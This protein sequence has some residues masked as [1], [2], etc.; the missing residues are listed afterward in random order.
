MS[1]EPAVNDAAV[2]PVRRV[3]AFERRLEDERLHDEARV[4]ILE[5]RRL[6]ALTD[7]AEQELRWASWLVFEVLPAAS[8]DARAELV[9]QVLARRYLEGR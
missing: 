8:P 5:D 9:G 6:R 2:D 7:A 1:P 4:R 3:A